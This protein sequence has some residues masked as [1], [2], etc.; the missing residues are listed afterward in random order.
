MC[1]V[2]GMLSPRRRGAAAALPPMNRAITHRGPDDHGSW[3]DESGLVGLTHR[4]L[5]IVDLSPAGHQP[6]VSTDGRW[7]LAF[8]GEI[9]DHDVHRKRLMAAGHA[10]RGTSDTEVLLELIARDGAESALAAVDGMFGVAIWDR[11][12]QILTLGRDRLG[13]KPMYYGAGHD[14]DVLFAS[15]LHAIR[16]LPGM[17]RGMSAEALTAYVRLGYVPAPLS[18]L[19]GIDKLP[20]GTTVQVSGDGRIGEPTAYWSLPDLAH[21]GRRDLIDADVDAIAAVRETLRGAVA[22]R[23]MG[24][25]PLG[26]F[27]SGGVD[28]STI[29][30][31]AQEVSAA[32]VRTFTVAVGGAGDESVA[33]AAVARHLGTEHTTI[34][35]PA[36]DAV[37]MSERIV[38]IYDEPF[39]DPSG[40]P[41]AM[42]CAATREH[43]TVALSGDGADELFGG[44]N[45]Y[46]VAGGPLGRA[47]ALPAPIRTGL[48]RAIRRVPVSAWDRAASTARVRLPDVGTKAHK[49]GRALATP[50][51]AAA[52]HAL[53][54]QWD[55][56]DVLLDPAAETPFGG[57]GLPGLSAMLLADQVG[58]LPDDMLVKVDRASMAVAL[59]V[60]VPFLS[61]DLV[62]LS[63]RL[64]D[65]TRIRGGQ[66]KWVVRQILADYVPRE[67]WERPKMGFDPPLA[68]WLRGPLRAWAGDLLSPQRLRAQG[69]FRSEPVTRAL[70]D[71]VAGRA[72]ND[73]PLWTML[74]LQAWLERDGKAHHG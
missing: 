61:P 74:M 10:F 53:G 55:P 50:D 47:L 1:G 60:R 45:R 51:A 64:P 13:E 11:D 16:S 29:V 36:I 66:G 44:Y 72:N 67:L 2:A 38:D 46:R 28:S 30:A 71:H 37:T 9:Y 12:R 41:T 32:P 34:D 4:R 58:L 35:L 23:L 27:L 62:E 54:M 5:A 57:T 56:A 65:T 25:V 31:V 48:A 17:S 22:R 20:P 26:A 68:A 6:M 14:G 39:A 59:E 24:D 42:L 69:L 21:A 52:H 40:I 70:E 33:A 73:Y 43:V 19:R 49:L 15:E 7:V 8:N 63:W 18:A 3:V